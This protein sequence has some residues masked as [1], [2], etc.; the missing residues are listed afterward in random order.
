M[1]A[2]VPLV[3]VLVAAE[4]GTMPPT[5][6]TRTDCLAAGIYK[7]AKGEVVTGKL[8]VAQV[9][10]NRGVDICKTINEPGQFTWRATQRLYYDQSTYHL[11]VTILRRG[12]AMKHFPA[13]NF[14]NLTSTP[15]WTGYITTI[16]NHKFY[17]L[18]PVKK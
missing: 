1:I 14:H 16:G 9:I 6:P 3:L 10:L 18:T 15:T 17:N 7:E 13:T 11:A 4:G 12:Y 2:A 8:A 5:N